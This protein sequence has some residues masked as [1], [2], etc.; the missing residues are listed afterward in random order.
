TTADH[1]RFRPTVE[2]L[3]E[4]VLPAITATFSPAGG[5]L[6]VVGDELD[7][8][9]VVSRDAAGTILVNNA[10][11]VIQGGPAIARTTRLIVTNGEGGND[12][13]SLNEAN[14]VLPLAAIF[15]GDGND[16]LTG[17]SGDDLIEGGAGN[18]VAF[19]GA[20]DD[21]FSWAP[22]DGSDVVE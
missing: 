11:V 4:R 16:T 19:L 5:T 14:G 21:T 22:G 1:R 8:A 15:G 13:P 20:G 2:P 9:I 6:R 18:D 12:N 7:N 3:A 17:G 10:A